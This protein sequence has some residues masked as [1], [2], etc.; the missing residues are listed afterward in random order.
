MPFA[1]SGGESGGNGR[2][3]LFRVPA[4]FNLW[5][6]EKARQL[7]L[8]RSNLIVDRRF[9]RSGSVFCAPFAEREITYVTVPSLY[10]F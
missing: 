4:D 7:H 8:L 10:N 5:E 3:L 2:T 9:R 1:A 6:E